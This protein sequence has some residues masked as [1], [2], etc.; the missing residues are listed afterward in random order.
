MARRNHSLEDGVGEKGSKINSSVISDKTKRLL[1]SVNHIFYHTGILVAR[2]LRHMGRRFRRL[3]AKGRLAVLQK[4]GPLVKRAGRFLKSLGYD[5]I[6]P[7]IALVKGARYVYKNVAASKGFAEGVKAFFRSLWQGVKRSKYEIKSFINHVVPVA[8]V[9]ALILLINGVSKISFALSVEYEGQQIGYVSNE[10]VYTE[11][12]SMMQ[13]RI[14]YEDKEEIKP[15]AVFKLAVVNDAQVETADTLSNKMIQTSTDVIAQSNG[16]YIDGEFYGAIEDA[17]KLEELLAS[18]K[19]K[20][21]DGDKSAKVEFIKQVEAVPALYPVESIKPFEEIA[22]VLTSETEAEQYYTVETGDAPLSIAKKN[23][24]PYS[25]LK[26]LNPG[27]EDDLYPG[28]K[29]LVSTSKPFLGVKVTKTQT[30]KESIPYESTT[31]ETNSLS[32][33]KKKVDVAG[34]N[35]EKEVKAEVTY[36]NGL[37]TGR[38]ILDTRVVKKPVNEKVLLGTKTYVSRG[39]SYSNSASASGSSKPT[40]PTGSFRWPVDGGYVSCPYHG[41][42]NHTGMDIAVPAGTAV[43]ASDSGQVTFAGWRYDYGYYV[44]IDH[45]NGFTTLY[46]HNSALAVSKGQYVSQGQQIAY[47]GRTGNATGNHCH[48]EVRY[49]GVLQNPANYIGTR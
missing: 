12:E 39:N 26:A 40:T 47:A 1:D 42:Y 11:A 48:F 41:Y 28:T 17:S 2:M 37:E 29:V 35:G 32:K 14:I 49:K 16:V 19:E 3:T 21:Q 9:F 31:V 6:C 18:M 44:V 22:S 43:R 30:Y 15:T 8:A 23:N 27:I 36:V 46:A 13:S 45:G 34:E 10:A 5:L 4:C 25:E 7:F 24:I 33:G 38:T 20:Y